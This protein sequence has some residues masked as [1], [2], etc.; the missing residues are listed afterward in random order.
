MTALIIRNKIEIIPK[1]TLL[2]LDAFSHNR[3]PFYQ[4]TFY[5]CKSEKNRTAEGPRHLRAVYRLL[6]P[7]LPNCRGLPESSPC[8]VP[9]PETCESPHS[10]TWCLLWCSISL[11]CSPSK[12]VACAVL[13]CSALFCFS[14][15][16]SVLF[17]FVYLLIFLYHFRVTYYPHRHP[18]HSDVLSPHRT[19]LYFHPSLLSSPL[20]RW[21]RT[22]TSPP[23]SSGT[24]SRCSI[25]PEVPMTATATAITTAPT[26]PSKTGTW[27]PP[28]RVWGTG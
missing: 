27:A 14:L 9:S 11:L 22:L 24:S 28:V 17:C 18:L 25:Q 23:P 12:T 20:S 1:N 2:I 19:D 5:K 3:R 13:F 10:E 4:R 8:C 26:C 6:R 7:I 16:C 21:P 15:F